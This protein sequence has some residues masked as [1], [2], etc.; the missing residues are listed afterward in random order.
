MCEDIQRTC[1]LFL[2]LF[3]ACISDYSPRPNYLGWNAKKKEGLLFLA[4]LVRPI[5]LLGNNLYNNIEGI[6][7]QSI[8]PTLRKIT[9]TS[10]S[11]KGSIR[12]PL[13]Y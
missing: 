2:F 3:L 1:N 5:C 13:I 10:F 7:Q 11:P 8:R 9:S 6:S 12:R 4:A